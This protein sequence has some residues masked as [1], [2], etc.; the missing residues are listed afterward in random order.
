M[1]TALVVGGLVVIGG[2]LGTAICFYIFYR[3][4]RDMW[5]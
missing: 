5:R 2:L 4:F 1:R 3:T